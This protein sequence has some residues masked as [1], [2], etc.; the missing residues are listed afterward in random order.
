MA[1]RQACLPPF[2]PLKL[3]VVRRAQVII[4]HPVVGYSLFSFPA[5]SGEPDPNDAS[6]TVFG[7]Y[8]PLALE[9][10]RVITNHAAKNHDDFLA[11]DREGT[12]P[13]H[14]DVT[15]L[16]PGDYYYFFGPSKEAAN[17]NY[18]IIKEFSALRFPSRIPDH[19][20]HTRETARYA[21]VERVSSSN[22][23]NHV[24]SRDKHCALTKYQSFNQCAHLVPKAADAWFDANKM[25]LYSYDNMA[26]GVDTHT[27]GIALRDDVR[28]CFDSNAFV[29]YPAGDGDAFMA[30]FVDTGG[31][32]D[33]TEQFHRR[34]ATIHPSVAVE[35]LYARFAYTVIKLNRL[36]AVFDSVPDN[37]EVK[38]IAEKRS[39]EK[40]SHNGMSETS[41]D[42]RESGGNEES[43]RESSSG[44]NQ[45]T[46]PPPQESYADG[47][48]RWKQ[49]LFSRLPEIATL[50][51]VEHPPDTVACHTETPHILRLTSKYMKE[52]PQVWQTSTTPE[53][54]TRDDVEGFY[55]KWIT[56]RPTCT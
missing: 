22:M 30:Y 13:V 46:Q 8:H 50:E 17:C 21:V 31:Y 52:N 37:A 36:S 53:G 56:R 15:T 45:S 1:P 33:Y 40:G 35:F 39:L 20:Y 54:A 7:V 19:W 12:I 27:N 38:V 10:C 49:L 51:E 48:E 43:D 11:K 44:S 47:D 34:P 29:F 26:A 5:Y 18:P 32:P 25:Y 2:K 23:S 42:S 14:R 4:N 9:S 3:E 16:T 41:E 6:K 24:A 28:R 55:A